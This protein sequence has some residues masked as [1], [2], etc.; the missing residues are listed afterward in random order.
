MEQQF[1]YPGVRPTCLPAWN[2]A[3]QAEIC[4]K[5]MVYKWKDIADAGNAYFARCHPGV[6]VNCP[7]N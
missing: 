4:L 2:L 1:A 3:L 6:L 5:K 7:K